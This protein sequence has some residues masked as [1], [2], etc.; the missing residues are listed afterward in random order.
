MA[1]RIKR[2]S[3]A[4]GS[5]I[6]AQL[7]QQA[8]F[9]LLDQP[10][11]PLSS[12]PAPQARRC[13]SSAS[14]ALIALTAE[15]IRAFHRLRVAVPSCECHRR[16]GFFHFCHVCPEIAEDHSAIGAGHTRERS[17]DTEARQRATVMSDPS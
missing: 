16:R 15:I 7:F 4:E 8:R 13:L 17:E 2:G 3:G 9:E 12:D 5:I 10:S 6:A 14:C 1:Q 11:L